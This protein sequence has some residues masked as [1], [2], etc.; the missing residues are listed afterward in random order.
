MSKTKTKKPVVERY[1]ASIKVLGKTYTS[2]GDSVLD[3]LT[4]LEGPKVARGVSLLL[5][6]KG[7][8]SKG[9]IL[10]SISVSRLFSPSKLTREMALKNTSLLF[11]L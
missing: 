10:S 2:E 1:S 3:A 7:S 4:R 9:R 11:D 5:V 6:S 8:S